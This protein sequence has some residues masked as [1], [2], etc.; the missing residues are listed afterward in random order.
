MESGGG[1]G[2]GGGQGSWGVSVHIYAKIWIF[3]T[4]EAAIIC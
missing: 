1:G 4:R 2:G 3:P